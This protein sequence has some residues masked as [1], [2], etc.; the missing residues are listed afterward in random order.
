MAEPNG[1]NEWG[2]H[3]LAE[4]VR[5]DQEH[6]TMSSK[7]DQIH[8]DLLM[9]KTKAAVWGSLAGTLFGVLGALLIKTYGG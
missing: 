6:Q 5:N 4:L 1:W 3:V 7:L 8:D 9:L 2:K